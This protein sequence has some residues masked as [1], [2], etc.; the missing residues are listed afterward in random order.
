MNQ[1]QRWDVMHCG[2]GRC[3]SHAAVFTSVTKDQH[4]SHGSGSLKNW[5]DFIWESDFVDFLL[6]AGRLDPKADVP[7]RYRP[8]GWRVHTERRLGVRVKF[9]GWRSDEGQGYGQVRVTV[10]AKYPTP[11]GQHLSGRCLPLRP[12]WKMSLCDM[13]H[14]W[15]NTHLQPVTSFW[16]QMQNICCSRDFLYYIRNDFEM[17]VG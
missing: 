14:F 3:Q 10:R 7:P 6:F 8:S 12:V 13:Q 5:V 16:R 9:R 4:L 17:L 1:Q 2:R 11:L 15:H